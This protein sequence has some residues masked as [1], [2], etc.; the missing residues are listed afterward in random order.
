V[1]LNRHD[2]LCIQDPAAHLHVAR[3]QCQ[4]LGGYDGKKLTLCSRSIQRG[5]LYLDLRGVF[6]HVDCAVQHGLVLRAPMR[7]CPNCHQFIWPGKT[8]LTCPAV[9]VA[10]GSDYYRG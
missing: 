5:D 9:A 1:R 4:C 2:Y 3:Q 8:H 6:Y 10:A 7:Q